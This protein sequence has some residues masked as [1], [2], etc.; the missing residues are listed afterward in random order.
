MSLANQL[1]Q[2]VDGPTAADRLLLM[3]GIV[4]M[5]E[6]KIKFL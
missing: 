1:I 5:E 4:A 2:I 6:V 3:F